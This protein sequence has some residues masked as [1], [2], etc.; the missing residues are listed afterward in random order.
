MPK[1]GKIREAFTYALN[2][3]CYLR[4]FLEDGQELFQSYCYGLTESIS[5]L[6]MRNKHPLFQKE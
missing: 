2:Q 6:L 5:A 3:E 4:V 1:S